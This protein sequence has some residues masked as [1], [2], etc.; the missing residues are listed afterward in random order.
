M[1]AYPF[2]IDLALIRDDYPFERFAAFRRISSV[3][4]LP[5][6]D[7]V[8]YVSDASGQFNL[9]RKRARVSPDGETY[10]EE[11]LTAFVDESVRHF[12]VTPS[13]D[14]LVAF[15]ADRH[16]DE[17]FQIYVMDIPHG[18][19]R[20]VSGNLKSRYEPSAGGFSWDGRYL[21]YS[22]NEKNPSSMNLQLFD[23]KSEEHIPVVKRD[24]WFIGGYWSPDNRLLS[25]IEVVDLQTTAIR[26]VD[27][28][29][30]KEEQ[31]TPPMDKVRFSPG[32][33]KSDGSGF[34]VLSDSGGEF[35]NVYFY[36]L[37]TR[38]MEGVITPKC[39]VEG[40]VLSR[41]GKWLI[42]SQN[43]DGYSRV[44]A[45]DTQNDT[46]LELGFPRAVVYSLDASQDGGKVA[47]LVDSAIHPPEVY[48]CELATNTV[49]RLTHSSLGRI[50]THRLV[51]PE[52]VRYESF[53]EREVPSYL[54]R[55][56]PI[57]GQ[58]RYPVV[59]S[60]H[61]GPTSQERPLYA[62][63]G[64]YQYLVNHGVGVF[65]PNFRGSTGYGKS[66]ERLI[67]RDWGGGELKD[68][69][70]AAK[71]LLSQSWVDPDRL[72]VFGGSFGGFATL[73]CVTRLADYWRA[74]VDIVGP[75]N[76]LTFVRSVPPHWRRFMGEWVGDP[77]RDGELLRERSPINYV[78]K[79]RAD[80]LIIQ[81]ANDPRV[82]KAESDQMV[83]KLRSLGKKVEY[84]VFEDEGHGFTKHT[85][86]LKA[87]R[88]AGQFLVEKLVGRDD[89]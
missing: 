61:G 51:E 63:W 69:E 83:E 60:I 21:A 32:P 15:F 22:T 68:F 29:S 28:Q 27:P 44:F 76:L 47:A 11:Q 57:Q 89:T 80:L 4:F 19:P 39:D 42:W 59:V 9:W 33:W 87:M 10:S 53:D 73:S 31:V 41:D 67:Y 20:R 12:C 36:S 24:G 71:Y 1:D 7:W 54:Y 45:A 84:I 46:R 14:E 26:L 43:E 23:V 30:G 78:D 8:G 6:G 77:E 64:L 13:G 2:V 17:N 65:A 5:E 25:F 79:I 72:G 66:Y 40:V 86:A 81:G 82:V 48:V 75:S 34:Y 49:H 88:T 58:Q 62:Y 70:W 56:L 38:K 3:S 55:P 16:G 85:N 18:W 37:D 50:P 52:N 35:V 74:A